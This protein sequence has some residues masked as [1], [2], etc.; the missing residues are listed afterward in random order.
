[1]ISQVSTKLTKNNLFS[2]VRAT[3]SVLRNRAL[4]STLQLPP[5]P[6]GHAKPGQ[7]PY[8]VS[9][10]INNQILKS[11]SKEWYDVFD[12]ATD[13]VVAKVPQSTDAE[14][15]LAIQAAE[16][17]FK[18]FSKVPITKRND[19]VF[20][21][22]ELLR[23][24]T[25]LLANTIVLE[26]GKTYSAAIA[27]VNRGIEC[28]QHATQVTKETEITGL[29]LST[30]VETLTTRE[31]I[32]VVGSI[33][34]FNFPVMIPL[35][36]IPYIIATGNTTVMKPSEL[37]PGTGSILADLA[38]QAGV[39]AGVINI[40]HGKH[41]TVNKLATDPRIKAV[42]FVGGNNAGKYVYEQAT[43]NHKRVQIN[44][45]AKNHTVVLP[46]ADK[47]SVLK[48]V[49]TGAFSSTGQVCLS[50][51]ILFLVGEAKKFKQDIVEEVKKL[52]ARPGFKDGVF[53]P[54]VTKESLQ[55]LEAVIQDAVDK[56]AE[57]LV[58]GRTHNKPTEPEFANGYF[59]GPTLLA[60]VKEGMKCVDEELFGPI[61]TIREVDTLQET[62]DY[63]N[64]NKFGNSVA[65][66]T[67]SGPDAHHFTQNVNIG[68][69]GVNTI[70][71]IGHA[72]YGFTSNKASFLGD[73]PFY[74]PSAFKFLT[75]PKTIIT[76]WRGI[77]PKY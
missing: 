8:L 69:V 15:D 35:W 25:E 62:I 54:V 16:D 6:T 34:P 57:V 50:T 4:L 66:F 21:Y 22:I 52:E 47:E 39:P 13:V 40:V 71:P 11:D 77:G 64:E 18:T 48:S 2:A 74:G 23:E 53:G 73:L 72:N 56:G 68:Q 41:A 65:I 67:Q 7:E 29:E 46:D 14:L 44:L 33:L 36:T 37:C 43:K 51:D 61:F 20:R 70:I 38:R 12:P 58:D 17:A 9:T 26:Q 3:R 59:I 27:D 45:G 49:V 42:T 24:N 76:S 63:V 75:E 5:K 1:M 30:S 32:G 28:A 10:Y 31:P 60:N 55:R 19:I